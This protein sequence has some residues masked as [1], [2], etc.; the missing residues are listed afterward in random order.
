MSDTAPSQRKP[1]AFEC[2]VVEV[3]NDLID[4]VVLPDS[5]ATDEQLELVDAA[6]SLLSCAGFMWALEGK[7]ADALY[8]YH[9]QRKLARRAAVR[10]RECQGELLGL[11]PAAGAPS[12]IC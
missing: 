6:M 11:S 8:L 9:E 7:P 4:L 2:G 12:L 1:N 5:G 10:L 3:V